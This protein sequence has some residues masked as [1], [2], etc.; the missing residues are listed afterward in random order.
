VCQG[1]VPDRPRLDQAAN[2]TITMLIFEIRPIRLVFSGHSLHESSFLR[3]GV[4]HLGIRAC[5]SRARI[6]RAPACLG[7]PS[8]TPSNDG[9]PS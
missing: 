4:R 8:I 1:R 9:T 3:C 7:H 2:P 5:S 6:D